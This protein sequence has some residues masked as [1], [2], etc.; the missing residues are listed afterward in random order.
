MRT[1]RCWC[2]G[3]DPKV[4]WEGGTRYSDSRQAVVP[5]PINYCARCD[6]RDGDTSITTTIGHMVDGRNLYQR[7]I[8]VWFMQWRN[9]RYSAKVAA[10]ERYEQSEAGRAEYL[11]YLEKQSEKLAQGLI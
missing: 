3:C 1:I 6:V 7:T 8:P 10:K 11:T 5:C 9:R 2:F 4:D